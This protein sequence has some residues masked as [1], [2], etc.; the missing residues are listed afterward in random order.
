MDRLSFPLE[1]VHHIVPFR[2][3]L[4]YIS[5]ISETCSTFVFVEKLRYGRGSATVATK[6]F[7]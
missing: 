1:V 5:V 6:L 4:G 2:T 3:T 7:A